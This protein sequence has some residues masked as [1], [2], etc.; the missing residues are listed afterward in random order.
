MVRRTGVTHEFFGTSAIVP[1]A[2][3][4]QNLAATRLKEAFR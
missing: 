2:E 3:Q 1:E 4:A